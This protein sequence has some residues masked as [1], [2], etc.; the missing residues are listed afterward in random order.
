MYK[1]PKV[2]ILYIGCMS[3]VVE[4]KC[5]NTSGLNFKNKFFLH[6]FINEHE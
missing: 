6:Q 2:Y 3:S 1:M 5:L 4:L